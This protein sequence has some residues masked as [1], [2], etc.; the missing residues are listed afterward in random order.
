MRRARAASPLP[1]P[2]KARGVRAANALRPGRAGASR[3]GGPVTPETLRTWTGAEPTPRPGRSE[4]RRAGGRAGATTGR[5]GQ[6]SGMSPTEQAERKW[7][8][9]LCTNHVRR[10]G[11]CHSAP[12]AGRRA[13]GGHSRPHPA[14]PQVPRGRGPPGGPA[15][16]RSVPRG[17]PPPPRPLRSR[18]R[19]GPARQAAPGAAGTGGARR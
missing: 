19:A 17:S 10:A 4:R 15:G 9:R 3:E 8:P 13:R 12:R 18:G 14:R 5:G 11:E 6:R 2:P 7:R 16:H 1:A